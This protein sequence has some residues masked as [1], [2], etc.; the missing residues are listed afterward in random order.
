MTELIQHTNN[1]EKVVFPSGLTHCIVLHHTGVC[2]CSSH[3]MYL[4]DIIYRI[5]SNMCTRIE[6]TIYCKPNAGYTN[7]F[8]LCLV[9]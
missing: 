5:L 3:R 2:N 7:V 9:Q 8:C 4:N 6:E 1:K